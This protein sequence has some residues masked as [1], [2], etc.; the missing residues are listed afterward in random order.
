MPEESEIRTLLKRLGDSV[1]ETLSN[2]SE[3]HER[4]REIRNAGYEVFI[5]IETKIAFC[6]ANKESYKK[7]DGENEKPACMN[8]TEHDAKFLKSLKIA[9][10]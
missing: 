3:I 10:N 9:I 4:I 5:T 8:L 7:G 6:S 1:N 2:S